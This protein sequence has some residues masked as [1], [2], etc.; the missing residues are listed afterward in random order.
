NNNT[1]VVN[2]NDKSYV[3]HNKVV[4]LTKLD[5][6][7]VKPLLEAIL[8]LIYSVKDNYNNLSTSIYSL[9][10]VV[11][12]RRKVRINKPIDTMPPEVP[13]EEQPKKKLWLIMGK[14][15]SWNIWPWRRTR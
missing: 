6:V 4:T 14:P 1:A 7:T 8:S 12:K 11:K 5:K 10:E 13:D 2:G 15:F 3:F 9:V